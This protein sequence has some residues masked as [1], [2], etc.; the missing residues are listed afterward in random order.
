MENFCNT[1][2]IFILTFDQMNVP[3]LRKKQQLFLVYSYISLFLHQIL[4]ILW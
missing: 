2:N 3:L 1:I 4:Y